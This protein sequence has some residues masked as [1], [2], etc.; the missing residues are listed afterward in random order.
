MP[1]KH[2]DLDTDSSLGGSNASDITIASQKATKSY[3]D[4]GLLGKQ[5]ALTP[6]DNITIVNNVISASITGSGASALSALSDVVITAVADREVLQYDITTGKW[7]N[8]TGLATDALV[9]HLA[10]SETITGDKTFSGALTLGS[11]AVATTPSLTD[12]STRIATTE[13]VKSQGYLTTIPST[14]A[15][16]TDNISQFTN[17]AEYVTSSEISGLASD[18]SVVHLTTS[19]SVS[20]DKTFTGTV[21]L[22]GITV[23]ITPS[24]TDDSTNVATTA[25]VKAQGYLTTIGTHNQDGSTINALTGYA[26]A[27]ESAAIAAGD[28]LNV[29]LGKLEYKVDNSSGGGGSGGSITVG[30][31]SGS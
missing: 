8:A 25:F 10:T 15:Q 22:N 6:G 20:G 27:T 2:Y 29:A 23:A 5:D 1:G 24:T 17:D 4:G 11:N 26:K 31:L 13:F 30:Q 7:I 28:S 9:V 12:A 3:V 14:Y 21:S 18:S 19:E 16:K